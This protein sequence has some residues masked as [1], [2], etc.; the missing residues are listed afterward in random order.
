MMVTYLL[1]RAGR[2]GGHLLTWE[3]GSGRGGAG[4]GHLPTW[5]GEGGGQ[6]SLFLDR[7]APVKLLPSLVLRTWSVMMV[8]AVRPHQP[9]GPDFYF[10]CFVFYQE[11]EQK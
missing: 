8:S 4:K 11:N 9:T 1:D 7:E 10:P 5:L 6:P 2:A 3:W